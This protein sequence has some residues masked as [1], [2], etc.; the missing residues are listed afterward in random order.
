[1][2]IQFI[3]HGM[4][5]GRGDQLPFVVIVAHT[6]K[7]VFMR[8]FGNGDSA[9]CISSVFSCRIPIHN[10]ATIIDCNE[11]LAVQ[12]LSTSATFMVEI[13]DYPK[14]EN[15]NEAVSST[16]PSTD[17]NQPIAPNNLLALPL[18]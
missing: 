18:T 5:T 8:Y 16:L 2:S 1:M 4:F 11:P 17:T 7:G 6:V 12:S 14:N 10:D 9:F 3:D 13:P 15:K